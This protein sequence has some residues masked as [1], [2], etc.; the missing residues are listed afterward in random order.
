MERDR[1]SMYLYT[2]LWRILAVFTHDP[3]PAEGSSAQEAESGSPSCC[4]YLLRAPPRAINCLLHVN[5]HPGSDQSFHPT[6]AGSRKSKVWVANDR[7]SGER[8]EASLRLGTN[9]WPV[10]APPSGRTRQPQPAC[11]DSWTDGSGCH[12]MLRSLFNPTQLVTCRT[13]QTLTKAS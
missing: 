4:T 3:A 1:I 9:R 8:K 10:R 12:S 7:F 5:R 6:M 11:D 13:L 2:L